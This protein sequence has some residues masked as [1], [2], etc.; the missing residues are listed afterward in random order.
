[1]GKSGSSKVEETAAEKADARVAVDQWNEYV[2]TWAPKIQNWAAD[3]AS[4]KSAE[5][6]TARGITNADLAQAT[7]GM[8]M[9]M[10]RSGVNPNSGKA[11]MA[12][13]DTTNRIASAGA[14]A[15]VSATQGVDNAQLTGLQQV[16]NIGMGQQTEAVDSM[17]DIARQSSAEAINKAANDQ[18]EKYT[19]REMAMAVAGTAAGSLAKMNWSKKVPDQYLTSFGNHNFQVD[20][21]K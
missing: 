3:V 19:N 1:M 2:T 21:M 14:G 13:E 10:A 20:T 12:L 5:K 4:D 15:Q 9:K 18:Q 8:G 6:A 16:A 7:K 17:G 11:I